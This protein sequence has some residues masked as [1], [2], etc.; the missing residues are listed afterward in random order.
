MTAEPL[1]GDLEDCLSRVREIRN[2]VQGFKRF[3]LLSASLCNR[4]SGKIYENIAVALAS[5][6]SA[7]TGD[8][9]NDECLCIAIFY[10]PLA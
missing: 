9:V 8:A 10:S 1:F 3:T 6:I 5:Y 7:S 4:L 2:I